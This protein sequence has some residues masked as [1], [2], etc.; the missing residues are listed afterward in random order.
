MVQATIGTNHIKAEVKAIHCCNSTIGINVISDK[1]DSSKAFCKYF[2]VF[3]IEGKAAVKVHNDKLI[4]E[5]P[6]GEAIYWHKIQT[7]DIYE[8]N[9]FFANHKIQK[10]IKPLLN[11]FQIILANIPINK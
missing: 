10:R 3:L 2:P 6:L 7:E 5:F 9:E 8:L 4:F 11:G 1:S